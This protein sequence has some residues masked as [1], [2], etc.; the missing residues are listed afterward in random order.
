MTL[1]SEKLTV[2]FGA[3]AGQN[4]TKIGLVIIEKSQQE[5]RTNYRTN[6]PTCTPDLTTPEG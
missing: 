4:F 1:T 5:Y 3:D 2:T 6:E